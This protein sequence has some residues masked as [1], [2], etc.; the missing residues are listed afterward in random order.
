[1]DDSVPETYGADM[2]EFAAFV[3]VESDRLAFAV[4][5]VS[6]FAGETHAV[7]ASSFV[8]VD[9]GV[10]PHHAFA[11]DS[12]GFVKGLESEYVLEVEARGESVVLFA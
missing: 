4:G 2:S 7:E 12:R 3:D 1:M 6:E 9:D 8:E 5:A 11:A 10:F